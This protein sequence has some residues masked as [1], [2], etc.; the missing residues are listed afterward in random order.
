V[1]RVLCVHSF[2]GGAGK[3]NASANI[4]Y[5]LAAR[6]ARV[7]VIDTDLASP[8]IH[9]LFGF[10]PG[11]FERSLDG[12]LWGD[13]GITEAALDVGARLNRPDGTAAL[14]DGRLWLVPASLDAGDI[15]RML[16]E[17]YDVERLG[18]GIGELTA[19]H[20]L[21]HVVLDTHPGL[22]EET[23]L[24]MAIADAVLVLMRPDL[25]HYQGTA[26][27]LR[28]ARRLEPPE[29]SLAANM[30]PAAVDV[31]ALTADLERTFDVP[32]AGCVPFADELVALG[33][34]ELVCVRSPDDPASVALHAIAD[35]VSG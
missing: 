1:S 33:S 9:A 25:Q 26:V 8:G 7:A 32:V 34:R 3:S 15:A 5:T 30:V 28:V 20:A 11:E 16:R 12:Y 13:H 10:E 27:T 18:E 29:L 17:G 35:R 24:S 6:G 31:A 14:P 4:A 23:L 2:R 19:A 22:D 21:D